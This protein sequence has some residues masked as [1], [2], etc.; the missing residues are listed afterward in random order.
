[1]ALRAA[2]AGRVVLRA[3]Q[4]PKGRRPMS[5]FGPIVNK[6]YHIPAEQ[7]LLKCEWCTPNTH[8]LA[9]MELWLLPSLSTDRFA[10]APCV[11]LPPASQPTYLKV[12]GDGMVAAV[13]GGLLTLSLLRLFVGYYD[14]SHGINKVEVQ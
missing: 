4:Q 11:L 3:V 13:G 2:A 9:Q 12:K 5:V 7:E 8:T 1:M 14:M 10:S 6:P